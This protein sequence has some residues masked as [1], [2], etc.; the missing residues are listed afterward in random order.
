MVTLKEYMGHRD[1]KTTMKYVHLSERRKAEKIKV[2][3][4]LMTRYED[5]RKGVA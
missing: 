5:S 2:F 4:K 3:D 1:L